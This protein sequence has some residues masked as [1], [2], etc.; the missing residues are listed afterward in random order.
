VRGAD[1]KGRRAGR[2][3]RATTPE[4]RWG[5]GNRGKTGNAKNKEDPRTDRAFGGG[6]GKRK[7]EMRREKI[8]RR[9][10]R[11]RGVKSLRGKA[12]ERNITVRR[13]RQRGGFG[14]GTGERLE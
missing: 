5:L 1:L 11:G 12:V 7:G 13:A 4:W 9:K 2:S 8:C 10:G 14:R 6:G 3:P